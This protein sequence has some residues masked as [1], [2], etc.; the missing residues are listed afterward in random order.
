MIHPIY[1]MA[2]VT[3]VFALAAFGLLLWQFSPRDHR[4]WMLLAMM[5]AGTL[6]S[7]PT[8]YLV[9]VPLLVA[10]RDK[11]LAKPDWAPFKG[12]LADD[13]IK[14][15]FAPLTEEP[16]KLV[17]WLVFLAIGAAIGI[18]ML[19]GRKMV[20]PIALALGLGFAI[21]EFWLVAHFIDQN[22]KFAATPWSDFTGYA[23]ERMMT[24][25]THSLFALPTV[26]FARRGWFWAIF[27]LAIGMTLHWLGNAPIALMHRE[28]FGIKAKDWAVLVQLWL[29]LF[30]VASLVALMATHYPRKIGQ[31]MAHRMVC[32]ECRTVYQQPILMGLNAG[33]W[34]YEP[35]GHCKKWHWVTIENLAPKGS[36]AGDVVPGKST[37]LSKS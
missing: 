13:A 14:L 8:Y 10:P 34:R 30:V 18:P 15:C 2:G 17:P 16:A 21:G 33:T 31:I 37:H 12:S 5:L 4:R 29:I 3:T 1:T 22:P 36:R 35:C 26:Y 25:L 32:P 24:C 28:A 9:R 19:P 11:L 23:G 20:V 27:G 6:T 7:V